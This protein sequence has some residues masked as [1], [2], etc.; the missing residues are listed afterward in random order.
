[1][2][3]EIVELTNAAVSIAPHT[4][5]LAQQAVWNWNHSAISGGGAIIIW[6]WLK[7]DVPAAFNWL[8]SYCDSH[9]GGAIEV[10]FHK[11]FGK[12]KQEITAEQ[13]LAS[14][15]EQLA[16]PATISPAIPQAEKPKE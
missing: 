13:M 5:T 7:A 9:E 10:L 8:Q 1:M 16:K 14:A 15:A 11:I 3:N 2:T 12:P 6:R 4:Y